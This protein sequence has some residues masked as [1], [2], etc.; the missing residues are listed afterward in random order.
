MLILGVAYFL[1]GLILLYFGSDWF[2][3]G[4]E[5]IAK[6][7]N[8][9]NFAIG[10]T[11]MAIGTSLPEILTSAYAS[12][13]HAP[14]ISI[15]N[16][17]GSCIC[18]IGL[19]LGLSAIIS[20]IIVDKNLMRNIF[21]YLLFVVLT[22]IVGFNG[23]SWID[24][25]I[26][27]AIFLIYLRWTVKNGNVEVSEEDKNGVSLPFS[28]VLLIVGLVGVLVGAE[29]FID[30]AKKI[31]LALNVSDRIIGF[32]LVAFGT[33]VPELMVSLAAAKRRLG[34]MVL[35]NV[36]GSNIADIG[37]ALAVGSLF[38]Y[39]PP[40]HLQISILAIMSLLLYLFARYS[41]IG[42]LQGLLFL[43]MYIIALISLGMV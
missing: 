22:A 18:N 37:G 41:K 36:V 17:I 9:S 1:L 25:I 38:M 15:G 7:F 3:L 30:G 29:L 42:R 11:V 10:A 6:H 39:L 8:I 31:A 27:L 4:G 24:G 2:V 32:T 20:P 19:V 21:V 26:L 16:A 40:E 35:G 14:G 34:G 33:S 13:I 12:Y 28:L 23:F 5:R 43:I